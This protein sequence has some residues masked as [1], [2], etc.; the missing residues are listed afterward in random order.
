MKKIITIL[1]VFIN[2]LAFS[3]QADSPVTHMEFL[4]NREQELSKSYLSYMS[5]VAHGNRARKMEKKRQEL[6]NQIRG[7]LGD[8]AKLRPYKGDA[9]LRD[10]YKNY[11]DILYKLFN[12]DYHK[13]VDMEAIAEE[14]YDAMEA[15]LLAQERA[16][17]VLEEAHD[18]IIPVYESFAANHNVQL[19]EG[20]DSR[21][22][23]KLRQVARVNKYYHTM[24][25]IFFKNFK[26]EAYM[27]DAYNKKD[28]NGFEQNRNSLLRISDEGLAML[29]T[30]KTFNNDRTLVSACQKLITF[31]KQEATDLTAGLT[32]L[33]IREDEFNKIK[34]AFDA[35]PQTKRTEADVNNYNQAV[36]E[37]NDAA[38]NANKNLTLCNEG[39][40]KT[41]SYWENARRKFMETHVPKSK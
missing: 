26:Q 15:Y 23:K 19:V 5:E 30:M 13:I 16:G 35:K 40:A 32:D 27:W 2:L 10:A 38:L 22:N 12:E 4:T 31:H 36:K 37:M 39:S 18:K 11:W 8:A 24:F 20:D 41:L 3:Q 9:S 28:I 1:F 14:S 7:S 17:L 6:I 25:L 21:M 34:K 29:D 33:L